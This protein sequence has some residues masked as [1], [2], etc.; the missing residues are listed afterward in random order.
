MLHL[1]EKKKTPCTINIQKKH[2]SPPLRFVVID[3]DKKEVILKQLLFLVFFFTETNLL[4]TFDHYYLTN[5]PIAKGFIKMVFLPS[6][7]TFLTYSKGKGEHDSMELTRSS[8]NP[9][10][11]VRI[12]F[13]SWMEY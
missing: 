3:Q 9:V 13:L 8:L 1:I 4:S 11:V 2:K 10:F 6:T 12:A 7:Y 5:V